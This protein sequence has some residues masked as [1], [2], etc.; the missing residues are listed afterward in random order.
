MPAQK[1]E[2]RKI[3]SA[4]SATRPKNSA[5]ES[6]AKSDRLKDYLRG[7][8]AAVLNRGDDAR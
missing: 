7:L 2:L 5:V 3:T 6:L 4:L 1:R 8:S